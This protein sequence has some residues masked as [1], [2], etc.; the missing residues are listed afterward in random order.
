M[1]FIFANQEF[2]LGLISAIIVW[3]VSRST[4]KLIDKTKVNSALAIILDIVQDIKINPA[5]RE[6]DD[7]AKKQLAVERATKSLPDK[8][9]N[10]IM[11]VFGTVG[12]AVEYVFHNRKWLF[13]IGKAIKGVF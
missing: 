7:Y 4:G 1:D 12:G 10:L 11:K 5:T 3:I 13:S 8:Q 6:L 2:L 9:T